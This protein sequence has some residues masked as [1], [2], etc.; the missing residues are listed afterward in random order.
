MRA[1]AGLTD[2]EFQAVLAKAAAL[3]AR[4]REREQAAREAMREVEAELRA[5]RAE[6]DRAWDTRR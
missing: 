6:Y 5:R 3:T 4:R 1:A 2:A